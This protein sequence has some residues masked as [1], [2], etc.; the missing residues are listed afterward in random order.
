LNEM[1]MKFNNGIRFVTIT[2]EGRGNP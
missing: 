2:L 1:E